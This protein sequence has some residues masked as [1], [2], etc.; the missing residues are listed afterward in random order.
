M[1]TILATLKVKEGKMEEIVKLLKEI[2]PKVKNSEPGCLT[3]LPHTVQGSKNKN[4]IIFYEKYTDKEAFNL[5]SAS[6]PNHFKPVFPLLEGGMD[7]KILD[8]LKI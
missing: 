1:I 3:Y 6:L 4:L 7:I 2:V 8:E 5:H